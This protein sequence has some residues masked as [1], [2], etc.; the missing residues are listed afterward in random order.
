[1]VIEAGF[2][3]NGF[4]RVFRCPRKLKG[5]GTME[6]SR[7]ADFA[8]FFGVDL[9]RRSERRCSQPVVEQG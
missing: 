2:M 9:G 5:L 8:N 4:A 6:G 3:R 7:E 1:M